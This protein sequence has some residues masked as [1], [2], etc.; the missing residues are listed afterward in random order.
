[1]P[2]CSTSLQGPVQPWKD[3][4]ELFVRFLNNIPQHWTVRN[5]EPINKDIILSWANEWHVKGG[6]LIPRFVEAKPGTNAQIRVKFNG[7]CETYSADQST[8]SDTCPPYFP[9]SF[10]RQSNV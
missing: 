3:Y 4:S 8:L 7:K 1:M 5:G 6:G 9:L 10:P 2:H